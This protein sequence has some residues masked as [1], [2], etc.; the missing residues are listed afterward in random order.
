MNQGT[1]QCTSNGISRILVRWEQST[2][3]TN[4]LTLFFLPLSLSLSQTPTQ[5][6]AHKT[7]FSFSG[8]TTVQVKKLTWPW[9][10]SIIQCWSSQCGLEMQ[11]ALPTS[12]KDTAIIWGILPLA[13]NLPVRIQMFMSFLCQYIEVLCLLH[14]NTSSQQFSWQ[15]SSYNLF[16]LNLHSTTVTNSEGGK[17]KTSSLL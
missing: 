5:L 3:N 8:N 12:M 16:T 6:H 15:D 13:F 9:H 17:M 7:L 14:M 11:H 4:L 1:E 2:C 10:V